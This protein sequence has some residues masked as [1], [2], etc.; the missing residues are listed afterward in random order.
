MRVKSL[1]DKIERQ[2][3]YASQARFGWAHTRRLGFV[4]GCQRSGTKMVMRVLE[5][6]PLTRIFHEND[7]SAFVDF[8]LRSVQ[9]L[10]R[11]IRLT[12]APIQVFKP[13]C[14][15]Q[16][17]DELLAEFPEARGVWVVR[18]P[19]DVANSAREKWGAH[20]REVIGCLVRGEL[21]TW[22]WRTARVPDEV[23]ESLR[24]VWR[25]DL[26]DGEG[27]LLWWYLRNALFFSQGLQDHDRMLVVRYEQLVSEPAE[28]FEPLFDHLGVPWSQE[29]V[30]RVRASSIGKRAP[31][32]ASEEILALCDELVQRFDA[33][34]RPAREA[35][36]VS[37][38]QV[39][40]DTLGRG[41][42]ERY[43]VVI[44][45]WFAEQGA[46]V[47]I[48]SKP[49]GHLIEDLR[50][51]RYVPLAV[52]RVRLALPL[53]AARLRREVGVRPRAIVA[54]SLATTWLGRLAWPGVPLV[55]VAHGWPEERYR[56]VGPLMNVAD[57]V[58]AVSPAVRDALVAAG[59][60]PEKVVVVHNGVELGG[61]GPRE[62]ELRARLRAEMGGRS[63]I[64]LVVGRL[65]AQKC[66]HHVFAIAD[67]LGRDD[68]GFAIAGT[69]TRADELAALA[70]GRDDV[71]MLGS[72]G[73]V[74]DLLGAAD[75]FL[76]CSDWEGMP[77]TTI[78][79]MGSSL[80]VVATATEGSDQLLDERCGI[81]V[82]VADV[83]AMTQAV[84]TLVDDPERRVRM[85]AAARERAHERFSHERMARELAE[86]VRQVAW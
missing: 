40:I 3:K 19:A 43:A 13:I 80:P 30:D 53:K 33:V 83:Q 12:P 9:T 61:L 81:V 76:N 54:N 25:D 49:G 63:T 6:S 65:E 21:D 35:R 78:E 74:P 4:F 72:R 50:G 58:V 14:D 55:N 66:H 48:T 15:S 69:G 39:L 57:R 36:L 5:R 26:S 27:A 67:A 64:V 28:T 11:L 38:I 59:T 86:V 47:C 20:Q 56:K 82:S 60:K 62:G 18:D 8:E 75:L 51:V 22:G 16:R 23:V 45:N 77:L 70:E 42:A 52:E 17:A 31:P 29:H 71:V 85:G 37:P 7:V 41:G 79:A 10:R 2:L 44:S 34:E 1:P 84:R 24:S 68:V 46:E 73:D 32:A